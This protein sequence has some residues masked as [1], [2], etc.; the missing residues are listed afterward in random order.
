MTQKVAI[1]VDGDNI[2]ARFAADIISKAKSCG[3]I[4]LARVYGGCGALKNWGECCEFQFMFSGAGKNAAD[5]HLAIQ[6]TEYALTQPVDVAVICTSD[7]DLVHLARSLRERGVQVLGCGQQKTNQAFRTACN[8]FFVLDAMPEHNPCS[9]TGSG[10]SD[11]DLK[12]R[13]EIAAHSKSGAGM[14]IADLA[15]TMHCKYG[16]KISRYPERT[17]RNYLLKRAALFDLDPRGREAMVRF[18]P[19][20]F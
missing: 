2:S 18:I 16:T 6:A 3:V 15:Q 1:F 9:K 11:L 8:D 12:I 20:G 5:L 4:S 7:S 14:R 13:S 17:W 10:A 19:G